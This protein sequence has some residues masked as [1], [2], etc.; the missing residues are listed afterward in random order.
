MNRSAT[1]SLFVKIIFTHWLWVCFLVWLCLEYLPFPLFKVITNHYGF[2][3]FIIAV[4]YFFTSTG[5]CL[6]A[7]SKRRPKAATSLLWAGGLFLLP[8]ITGPFLYWHYL[9]NQPFN[10]VSA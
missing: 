9:H 3:L 6:V 1:N 10:G 8:A 5:Y 7:L 2:P 4:I